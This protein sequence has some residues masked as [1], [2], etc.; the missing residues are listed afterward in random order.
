VQSLLREIDG[1]RCVGKPL[2]LG[3]EQ[4]LCER[5][6]VRRPMLLQALRI[7]ESRG[8]IKTYRGRFGGIEATALSIRGAIEAAM[9]YLSTT[10]LDRFEALHWATLLGERLNTFA[11]ERWSDD[12]QRQTEALLVPENPLHDW[13]L[14]LT[15]VQWD[16]CRNRML[17]FVAR[18]IAAYQIRLV[19]N[20]Y[21]MSERDI[22]DYDN[23]LLERARAMSRGDLSAARHAYDIQSDVLVRSL[24]RGLDARRE[25]RSP[26]ASA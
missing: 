26:M 15:F 21:F 2:W 10:R 6:E 25:R 20:G 12:D 17:G 19:P 16:A 18:C 3:S 1:L 7:L 8:I 4:A 24:E 5:H 11:V 13:G 23:S 14:W 9:N 22:T